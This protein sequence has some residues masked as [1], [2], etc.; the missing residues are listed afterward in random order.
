MSNGGAVLVQHIG[1]T[2]LA[3]MNFSHNI[4]EERLLRDEIH[5]THHR[6]VGHAVLP[7]GG[8][9]NDGHLAGIL[10]D[11][12]IGN[13]RFSGLRLLKILPIGVVGTIKNA[14]SVERQD[15]APLK[16]MALDAL[17]NDGLLVRSGAGAAGQPRHVAGLDRHILNGD[18]PL[19]DLVGRD[20]GQLRHGLLQSSLR[21]PEDQKSGK[22]PQQNH[23]NGHKY[24]DFHHQFFSDCGLLCFPPVVLFF[25][26]VAPLRFTSHKRFPFS[27][28]VFKPALRQSSFPA[29]P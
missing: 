24:T 8:G 13:P 22:G 11:Q 14:F 29:A 10:A 28:I 12:R 5:H 1:A 27:P 6:A 15:V 19:F 7:D 9:D 25:G 16:A 3:D 17:V 26:Y 2:V 4:V 18:Q 23:G 21:T 20:T